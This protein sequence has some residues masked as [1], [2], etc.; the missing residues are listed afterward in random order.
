MKRKRHRSAEVWKNAG[1]KAVAHAI[2]VSVHVFDAS[3]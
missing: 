2:G 3:E 1:G